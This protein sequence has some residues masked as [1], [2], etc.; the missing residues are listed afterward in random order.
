MT[1]NRLQLAAFAVFVATGLGACS[2]GG[3]AA[4]AE[5][6]AAAHETAKAPT[7]PASVV[8][9]PTGDA[10]HG[11]EMAETTC[12]ACHG[13]GGDAPIDPSYPHLAGQY[14]DYLEHSLQMYRDGERDHP[15]MSA[16]AKT[17][18]DQQIADVAAYF[19]SQPAHLT[20]LAGQH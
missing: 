20:D 3:N 13:K 12:A 11:K 9:L 2:G 19:S 7:A 6:D 14:G 10:A 18:T 17:L 16:Q 15:I 1:L 4:P 8:S 5:G